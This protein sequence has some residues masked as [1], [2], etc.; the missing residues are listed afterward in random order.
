MTWRHAITT[1]LLALALAAPAI[2][3]AATRP[4]PVPSPTPTPP[5][6]APPGQVAPMTVPVPS[7]VPL[8]PGQ[9]GIPST[10]SPVPLSLHDAKM[11]AVQKSPQLEL[12]RAALDLAG[13]E[14]ETANS[15]AFPHLNASGSAN[16]L[17]G[18]TRTGATVGG[19]TSSI[20]TSNT[21]SINVQ[22]LIFDGGATYAKMSEAKYT[23]DAASFSALRAIDSVL[24]NVAQLYYT[25]LQARYT[26]QV[27]IES[28][29]LAEVQEA[30]VE[31]QFRAGVASKA[32]VLTAQ[33][34][35][36]QARL[37]EAQAANGE[38]SQVAALLN[39][40]GLSSDTPVTLNY[41]AESQVPALPQYS[42]VES[43]AL[44]QRTDLQA[45]RASL[46][47][48]QRGVRAARASRYPV[49]TG[50]GSIGTAT[51]GVD[52]AGNP[53]TN[54]GNWTSTYSFG[55][56]VTLPLYDSGLINGQVASAEANTRTAAANLTGTELSV[57]LS[58]RQAYLSTQTALQQVAAAKVEREQAQT[59][60]DVTNAQYKAGVTTLPLLLNAQVG[61]TKANGDW[62]NALFAAY[63][64]LQNLYF[65]EGIIATR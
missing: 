44:A 45:A 14:L 53:V 5:P 54:G 26:Y 29:K 2:A 8:P 22:Q 11:I 1:T 60:L 6:S 27:A 33:L 52:S 3:A 35:V 41:E 13:A 17:K 40:M 7:Y 12:A 50:N 43:I 63:T 28:R 32:D 39:A 64:A 16:R 30:L 51:T 23:R 24:F 10:A 42:T 58:V 62:V 59:V 20:F 37:A 9:F 49:I 18:Q 55:A 61:L 38:Q 65:A 21:G 25:A 15:A 34:P 56:S 19:I 47:S 36:A 48:A 46:T 57:S 4:T 31:A